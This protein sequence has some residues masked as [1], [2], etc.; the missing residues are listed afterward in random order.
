MELLEAIH[1]RRS[2]RQYKDKPVSEEMVR[3]VLEAA[4]MAP[5]AGNV[6]PW[7]FV[8]VND[9]KK[10]AQVKDV[11]PYVGM[12]AQA[13]LGILVCGDLRLEKFAGFWVQDCS[14]AMQNLLLAA[15]GQ[16]LGAVWTG[17]HPVEERVT[18]FRAIFNL[19]DP[20]IP[21]GFAVIG[22]PVKPGKEKTR[23]KPQRVHRNGWKG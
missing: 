18:R 21:L 6:Q 10:M 22:W 7:Q 19:P 4:M 20:V 3:I 14:A 2:I 1:T 11:H 15:H 5:S 12:A 23:Y 13:P 17:V 16:G 8:V 9:R